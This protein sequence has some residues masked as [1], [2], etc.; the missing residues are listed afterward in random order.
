MVA[1]AESAFQEVDIILLMIEMHHPENPDI[2]PI[3][4]ILKRTKKPAF[5]LINKIDKGPR[6][7]LLPIIDTYCRK[8]SFE[9]IVPISALKGDG[10]ERLIQELKSRLK[11]GPIF[12]PAH[13]KTDQS[14]FF[15][16]SEIIRESI[17][18]HT[19]KELPYSTAVRVEKMEE[20][21]S[22]NLLTIS[23]LVYVE[24]QSQKAILIGE[25]GKMIKGIGTSAR[26]ELE[27]K[28]GMRVFLGL[29]VKVEKNWS[30][31]PQAL[32]RLGY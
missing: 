1:S 20:T 11:K 6:Q 18:F 23:A 5:L 10:V 32:R 2:V 28:F 9:A 27:K 12:F 8:H 7:N 29:T 22:Q 25:K 15:F 31:D 19:R 4:R 14:E 21:M 13:M 17:Y 24:S 30:K 3:L 16:I 26:L